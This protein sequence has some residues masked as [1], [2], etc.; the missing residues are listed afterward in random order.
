MIDFL[1]GTH[2][3]TR[4]MNTPGLRDEPPAIVKKLNS[5]DTKHT[6]K[7]KTPKSKRYVEK[8]NHD[9]EATASRNNRHSAI[10]YY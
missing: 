9:P 3:A 10:D 5:R 2:S 7:F 8:F 6:S 1:S 4:D